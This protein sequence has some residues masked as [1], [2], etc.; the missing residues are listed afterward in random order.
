MASSSEFCL[1]SSNLKTCENN[2]APVRAGTCQLQRPKPTLWHLDLQLTCSYFKDNR[3]TLMFHNSMGRALVS[4]QYFLLAL[5][6]CCDES[7]SK[8]ALIDSPNPN[9]WPEVTRRELPSTHIKARGL[10]GHG[11]WRSGLPSHSKMQQKHNKRLICFPSIPCSDAQLHPELAPDGC[12]A[13][14][15][16]RSMI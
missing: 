3:G 11:T 4:G 2:L 9:R 8:R 6:P 5:S 7:G 1:P 14:N 10:V 15:G 16:S 13:S 12:F